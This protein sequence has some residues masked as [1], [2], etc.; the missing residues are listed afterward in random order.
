MG[1]RR[2]LADSEK[3]AYVDAELCLMDSPAQLEVPGLQTRWD[4]LQWIHISQSNYIHDVVSLKSYW[5]RSSLPLEEIQK[6]KAH[7]GAIPPMASL[8]YVPP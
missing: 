6:L 2:N 5:R 3:R 8:L 4:D 7:L 1:L